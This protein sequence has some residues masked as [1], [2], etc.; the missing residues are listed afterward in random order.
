MPGTM[1]G[2][3]RQM[4]VEEWLANDLSHGKLTYMPS[5]SQPQPSLHKLLRSF[6]KLKDERN[7]LNSI[8]SCGK[9]RR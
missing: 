1:I 6:R 7:K 8:G 4:Y 3:K 5:Q 2:Y 9:M